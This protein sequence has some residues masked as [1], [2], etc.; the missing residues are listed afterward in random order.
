MLSINELAVGQADS[1]PTAGPKGR[2]ANRARQHELVR[3]TKQS[4]EE[5]YHAETG[6][7]GRG[8]WVW[9]DGGELHAATGTAVC[10]R[11]GISEG[12]YVRP[13]PEAAEL[14]RQGQPSHLHLHRRRTKHD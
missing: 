11:V 9:R 4:H 6:V 10:S 8:H 2:L 14:P 7:A 12:A 13:P 3:G 5:I 1:L